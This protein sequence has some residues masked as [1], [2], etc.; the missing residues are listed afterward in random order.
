MA[1]LSF[2]FFKQNICWLFVATEYLN[3]VLY[4]KIHLIMEIS[5]LLHLK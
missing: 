5:V 4:I 3:A 2:F 1:E